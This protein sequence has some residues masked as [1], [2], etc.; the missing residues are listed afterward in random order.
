MFIVIKKK[1]R[2]EVPTLHIEAV[3]KVLEQWA[4]VASGEAGGRVAAVK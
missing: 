4:W 2:S 3:D 1:K